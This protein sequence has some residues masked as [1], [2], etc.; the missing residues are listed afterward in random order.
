[1]NN[2]ILI[3]MPGSGKSTIGV[4]LAKV[5]GYDFIDSDLLIQKETGRLLWQI[6]EKEGI[7]GFN[8]I[9]EKVN[10]SIQATNS[11]IA[12][13]GSAVYGEK[14]MRHL[15]KI[16]TIVYLDVS[17]RTLKRRLGDLKKR[18]VVLKPNQT[19]QDLYK[20]RLTLYRKYAHITIDADHL[21]IP[22]TVSSIID[23]IKPN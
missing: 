10:S 11:V 4:V 2:I 23:A 8:K 17:Y 1:M 15:G 6:M 20:E 3:G 12:T 9:E 5:L 19:L 7:D 13:G 18:G 16:G 21:N 14:A 22:Q